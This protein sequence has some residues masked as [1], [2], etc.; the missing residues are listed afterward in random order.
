MTVDEHAIL[1]ATLQ[2]MQDLLTLLHTLG[3]TDLRTKA[4]AALAT[5]VQ[6]LERHIHESQAILQAHAVHT[7]AL[8]ELL[9]RGR[10]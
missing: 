2:E 10:P 5:A 6:Q 8:P 3:L 9:Q 4:S 1:R 7:Q